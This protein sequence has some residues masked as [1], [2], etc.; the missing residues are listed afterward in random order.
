MDW[1]R[2]SELSSDRFSLL[3]TDDLETVQSVILSLAGG[4]SSENDELSTDEFRY[5]TSSLML[6]DEHTRLAN[7]QVC[8]DRGLGEVRQYGLNPVSPTKNNAL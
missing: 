2:K 5:Y 6:Q 7:D 3:V 4:A 1:F 8:R